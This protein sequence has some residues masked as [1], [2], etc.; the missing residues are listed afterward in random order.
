M[1]KSDSSTFYYQAFGH[2]FAGSFTRPTVTDIETQ[3]S[4]A[5]PPAGGATRVAISALNVPHLL[6]FDGGTSHV[7]GSYNEDD[8]TYN[9]LVTI[10][11]EGL[12]VLNT[13]LAD[14]LILK[15]SGKH[16][17]GEQEGQ[18]IPL[19]TT[20]ENLRVAGVP[21]NVTFDHELFAAYPT[22]A[23]LTAKYNGDA[24]FRATVRKQ[25]LWG[26]YE[27]GTPD[28]IKNRYAWHTNP[29]T[30]P[31]SKGV[32]PCTLVKSIEHDR[33][34]LLKTYGN[35]IVVPQFGKVILGDTIIKNGQRTFS[36]MRLELG[37]PIAG[38]TDGPL[39]SAGGSNY[40]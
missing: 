4:V 23:S 34:N 31:E 22:M 17:P 7:A 3:G 15:L 24:A 10:T 18:I 12:N 36:L 40:P 21:I 14:R 33:P 38:V 13:V 25:F 27:A 26:D 35:I 30:T 29:D 11:I 16:R 32:L 5:L 20:I 39:G 8:D 6:S 19:G 28:F 37:S 9:T 2:A 1:A